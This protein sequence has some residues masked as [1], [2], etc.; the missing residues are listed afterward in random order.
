MALSF[1]PVRPYLPVIGLLVAV[2]LLFGGCSWGKSIQ[3]GAT[4]ENVASLKQSLVDAQDALNGAAKALR[5]QNADNKRRIA[6]AER[7]AKAAGKLEG[8]AEGVAARGEKAVDAY[9][10]GLRDAGRKSPD[11]EAL[12]NS[13]VL[14]VCRL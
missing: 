2:V 9:A 11:C 6:D 8:Y 13:D 4:A 7:T 3:R 10:K 12:L 14:R 1:D 5:A